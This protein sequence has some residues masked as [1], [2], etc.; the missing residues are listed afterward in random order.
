MSVNAK[1]FTGR[2]I[3]HHYYSLKSYMKCCAERIEYAKRDDV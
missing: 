3:H 1:V 2:T